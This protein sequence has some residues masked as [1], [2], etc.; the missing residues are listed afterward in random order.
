MVLV[1]GQRPVE[2]RMELMAAPIRFER[3]TFPLGGGRS[4]QLSYGA[5]VP[6]AATGLSHIVWK[7]PSRVDQMTLSLP[8]IS[9]QCPGNEQKSV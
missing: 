9:D 1:H 4:I 7:N 6:R 3:T 5:A 2:L 8:F